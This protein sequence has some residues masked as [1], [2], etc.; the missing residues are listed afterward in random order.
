MTGITIN[1]LRDD[2][3][4]GARVSGLT[5]ESLQDP[6]V[7]DE[8]KRT[9]EARGMIVFED[10]EPSAR[11]ARRGQQ[12]LRP[13]Q[14]PSDQDHQSRRRGSRATGVIDM[15]YKPARATRPRVT[16]WSR[17]MARSSPAIR[18]GISTIATTTSST[19]PA[20]C[21]APINA[22]EGGRTGFMDGVELYQRFPKELRD[23][24]E[25]H[26]VIYTLDTRLSKM[27]YRRQLQAPGR[28]LLD[29]SSCSRKRR[30]SRGR[31]I[32]RSGPARPAR[33]CCTSA[34]GWRSASSIT[35]TRRATR[36][37]TRSARRSIAWA[38]DLRPTGTSGSRPTWSIWDNWRMLHA[39]EGCDAEVRA[40]HPAH[41]DQGRLRPRLFRG[42]QE[43][44]RSPARGRLSPK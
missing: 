9:F 12:G 17:S 4:F 24:I 8:L 10:V 25:G 29:A 7:R 36:C 44:R 11:D 39:V 18:P 19:M 14:G 23:K 1:N 2:L 5:F 27:R 22:P 40:P 38:K 15:H 28:T 31:C 42:R 20:C 3:S 41:H 43:D 33:R 37:S 21:A 26:N 30:S 13:A 16:G 35:R 34:R 6:A 32:R